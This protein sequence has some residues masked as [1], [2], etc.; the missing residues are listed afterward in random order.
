MKNI[1]I[2]VFF[3][4]SFNISATEISTLKINA[5]QTSK[6]WSGPTGIE[7]N[8]I[9]NPVNSPPELENA[10]KTYKEMGVTGMANWLYK[11]KKN[12]FGNVEV[13]LFKFVNKDKAK[14]WMLKK[15][16]HDGWDKFY[17]KVE[18]KNHTIYKSLETNKL[19]V[20]ID[21]YWITSSTLTKSQ[22]HI[23]I[24]KL[25]INKI[26]KKLTNKSKEDFRSTQISLI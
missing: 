19:I 14:A 24:M 15:Y 20:F 9:N 16:E 10:L 8:D 6:V 18:E 11:N 12:Q 3:I 13:K 26:E 21:K 5:K 2:T 22:D 1:L 4:L 17:E 7:I 23:N 25:Y